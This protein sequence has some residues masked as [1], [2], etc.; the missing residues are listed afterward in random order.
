MRLL[1]QATSDR[2]KG[3]GIVLCQGRFKVDIRR[4]ALTEGVVKHRNWLPRRA[5]DA[6]PVKVWEKPEKA[7]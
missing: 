4:N 2:T 3:N 5:A 6:P 1:S 7:A